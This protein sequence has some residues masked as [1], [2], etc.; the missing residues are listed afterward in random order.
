MRNDLCAGRE[1]ELEDVDANAQPLLKDVV[2]VRA[3]RWVSEE[4]DE[5]EVEE[6]EEG[7]G[8]WRK[9]VGKEQSGY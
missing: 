7:R 6:E 5:E 8:M 4:E 3:G 1:E 9:C 2:L